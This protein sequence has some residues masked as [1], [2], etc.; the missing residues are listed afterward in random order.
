MK[1][2]TKKPVTSLD[3]LKEFVPK[4]P[5]TGRS[6]I[7]SKECFEKWVETRRTKPKEPEKSFRKVLIAHLRNR[8]GRT[9]FTEEEETIVTKKCP[10]IGSRISR[11][12]GYH[13]GLRLKKLGLYNFKPIKKR[14]ARSQNV[15]T[16]APQVTKKILDN[17]MRRDVD[18]LFELICRLE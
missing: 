16:E 12:P 18:I 9:P 2:I 15:I 17:S 7:L 13:E 3:V 5:I 14:K 4:D 8:D 6:R 11:Q 1:L 10:G